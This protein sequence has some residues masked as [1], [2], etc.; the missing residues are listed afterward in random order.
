MKIDQRLSAFRDLYQ[1]T[2]LGQ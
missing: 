2:V 1:K